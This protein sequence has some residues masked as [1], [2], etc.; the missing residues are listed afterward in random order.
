MSGKRAIR[1]MLGKIAKV[2]YV[3]ILEYLLH[4]YNALFSSPGEG[5]PVVRI[6]FLEA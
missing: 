3:P 6:A 5:S 1:K 2:F 4:P